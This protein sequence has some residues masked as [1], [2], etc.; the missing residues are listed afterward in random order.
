MNN[1][2]VNRLH[3]HRKRT[4]HRCGTK[5]WHRF[6]G[7]KTGIKVLN[8]SRKH[9]TGL[10]RRRHGCVLRADEYHLNEYAVYECLRCGRRKYFFGRSRKISPQ[11]AR[12][13]GIEISHHWVF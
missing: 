13:S 2:C 1:T 7:D 12:D 6:I 5:T 11:Q 8:R 9:I 3:G 10:F 4:C